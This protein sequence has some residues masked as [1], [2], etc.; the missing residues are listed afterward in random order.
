MIVKLSPSGDFLGLCIRQHR[1][2]HTFSSSC[3]MPVTLKHALPL[4]YCQSLPGSGQLSR[5]CSRVKRRL[6][7]GPFARDPIKS[8]RAGASWLQASRLGPR[9]RSRDGRA[10]HVGARLD[11]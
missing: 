9:A 6:L 1:V 10:A 11:K 2:E 3:T 8:G 7:Q 5:S 4:R